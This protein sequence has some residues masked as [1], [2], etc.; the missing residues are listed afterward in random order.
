M[1]LDE[2]SEGKVTTGAAYRNLNYAIALVCVL[3]IQLFGNDLLDSERIIPD[4]DPPFFMYAEKVL[5]DLVLACVAISLYTSI[6][7]PIA[8]LVFASNGGAVDIITPSIF[9][10][11]TA[12]FAV[13]L[14]LT[15]SIIVDFSLN[16]LQANAERERMGKPL[17]PYDIQEGYRAY[18]ISSFIICL[19]LPVSFMITFY[20]VWVVQFSRTHTAGQHPEY[21]H[22]IQGCFMRR[23]PFL[24]KA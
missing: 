22:K 11:L 3:V 16:A 2:S 12:C 17:V 6:F 8:Q 10:F 18:R 20:F 7:S 4:T 19:L 9:L 14:L 23:L 1:T 21:L 5:N 24:I 15:Y 13:P